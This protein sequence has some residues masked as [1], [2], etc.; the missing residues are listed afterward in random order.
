MPAG[1]IDLSNCQAGLAEPKTQ[2]DKL[3]CAIARSRKQMEL[4]AVLG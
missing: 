1:V 2:V 4:G 3:C